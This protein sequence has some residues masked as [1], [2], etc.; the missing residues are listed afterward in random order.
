MEDDRLVSPPPDVTRNSRALRWSRWRN[1]SVQAQFEHAIVLFL[2]GL[3]AVVVLLT[4][5]SLALKVLAILLQAGSF[6]A[7]DPAA[8]QNHFGMIFTVIIAMEFR[9]TLLVIT[10]RRLASCTSARSS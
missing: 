5:W 1:L 4:V 10:E 9:Q 7:T 2:S 3:I 8:F 6:D